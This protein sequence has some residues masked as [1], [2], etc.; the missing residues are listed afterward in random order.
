MTNRTSRTGHIDTVLSSNP[1]ILNTRII[2]TTQDIETALLDINV[3]TDEYSSINWDDAS[4]KIRLQMNDGSIFISDVTIV[5]EGSLEYVLSNKEIKHHGPVMA[6]LYIHH[7]DLK[8]VR[9]LKFTFDI[10]LDPM[11]EDVEVL[12]EHYVDSFEKLTSAMDDIFLQTMN[13]VQQKKVDFINEMTQSKSELIEQMSKIDELAV[14][15][16][17]VDNTLDD[18]INRLDIINGEVI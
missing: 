6:T 14:K 15:V 1:K 18:L 9:L 8:N 10:E 2:F 13:D 16:K 17:T 11:D 7:P 3:D 4:S 5:G 12:K